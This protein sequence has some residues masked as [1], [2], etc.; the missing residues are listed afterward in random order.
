MKVKKYISLVLCLSIFLTLMPVS[1]AVVFGDG[2][3]L[4]DL[5]TG[6]G[7]NDTT[8]D[9]TADDGKGGTLSWKL[10]SKTLTLDNFKLE[11][12]DT[13]SDVNKGHG[14]YGLAVPDGTTIILNGNNKITAGNTDDNDNPQSVSLYCLGALTVKSNGEPASLEVAGGSARGDD[15]AL[16]CGIYCRTALTVED[17]VTIKAMSGRADGGGYPRSN[18]I[19]VKSSDSSINFDVKS[20]A[21]I[22]ARAGK[23]YCDYGIRMWNTGNA[24]DI[25]MNIE[26][27]AEVEAYN[28]NSGSLLHFGLELSN[29][30]VHHNNND[31]VSLEVKGSLK[32]FCDNGD[33]IS[34][35]SR[36]NLPT[37]NFNDA[38]VLA[39][40]GDGKKAVAVLK[41][42]N[43]EH[44]VLTYP[45]SYYFRSSQNASFVSY[46]SSYGKYFEIYPK[47]AEIPKEPKNL[48]CTPLKK[49]AQLTWEKAESIITP[50]TGYELE[51]VTDDS[52]IHKETFGPDAISATITGLQGGKD[53]VFSL[54]SVN[55]K[56]KSSISAGVTGYIPSDNA[57]LKG[58][59][60]SNGIINETF[61]P[62][63]LKYTG[64][65]EADQENIRIKPLADHDK[66]QVFVNDIKVNKGD[67]SSD[68]PLIVG[69]NL[70][71]VK[72]VSEDGTE[73]IYSLTINRP[74]YTRI[75]TINSEITNGRVTVSPA[76]AIEGTNITVK[77]TPFKGYHLKAIY[78]DNV[79]LSGNTF[80]MPDKNVEVSAEF[81]INTYT[82][83]AESGSKGRV[84]PEG[85]VTVNYGDSK[86]FDITAGKGYHIKDILVDGKSVGPS[87]TY[88]FKYIDSAHTI[89]AVFEKKIVEVIKEEKPEKKQPV[90]SQLGE[91][92]TKIFW[93]LLIGILL[94]VAGEIMNRKLRKK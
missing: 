73:K 86:T 14:A 81:E 71:N 84:T 9:F 36:N 74:R 31:S 8:T 40:A 66:A 51:Y 75:I 19:L 22:I 69:D 93:I 18:G 61:K 70:I 17:G 78:V 2:I 25:N 55:V 29:S 56:G 24:G 39:S 87:E 27:G 92:G 12:K 76:S 15:K 54:Y 13:S 45:D 44:P 91:D 77:A 59:T 35:Y 48:K 68:I 34:A 6:Y 82:I 38:T 60:L 3:I 85:S 5:S 33:G 94:V 26:S 88:E 32:A 83:K 79:K 42:V 52:A 58:L 53:Y 7:F 72:V 47:K 37:V 10:S 41:G 21:R 23:A 80:T 62:E 64:S 57:D 65:V 16:S 49:S 11:G 50:I 67:E 20:G 46:S 89:G 4:P 63:V 1:D 90:I 28:S 30:E 43:T